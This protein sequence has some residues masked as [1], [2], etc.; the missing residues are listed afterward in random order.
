MDHQAR[1]RFIRVW[2]RGWQRIVT[3]PH[4]SIV[5]Q[6]DLIAIKLRWTFA[7]RSLWMISGPARKATYTGFCFYCFACSSSAATCCAQA[8]PAASEIPIERCDL[9]PIVKVR[10]D[11]TDMR[12]LLDTAATSMLN[13]NR[14]RRDAPRKF[15]SHHLAARPPPARAKCSFLRFCSAT[16]GCAT[17]GFRPSISVLSENACGGRIDG[18]LGVDLLD[19]DGRND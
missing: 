12:F 19:K 17:S 1:Q 18:I 7:A 6:S 4:V 11:G 3:D 16:T 10:I 8:P 14:F 15:K 9:L 2:N 13:L 5:P